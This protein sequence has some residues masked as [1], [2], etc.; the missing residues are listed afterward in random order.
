MILTKIHAGLGNQM[1]QYAFGRALALQRN[2]VL[3]FDI[4]SFDQQVAAEVSRRAY[5]LNVFNI[6]GEI[7]T[8][9]ELHAMRHTIFLTKVRQKLE[10]ELLHRIDLDSVARI[11]KTRGNIYLQGYW[12][13][14]EC[15]LGYDDVIRSE[16]TLRQP[17][18]SAAASAAKEI[19]SATT[20]IALH[21]RRGDNA[22]V[23]S[24]MNAFGTPAVAYYQNAPARII[25]EQ[26]ITN[27]HCFVFSDDVTWVQNNL[28][29]PWPTTYVSKPGIADYEEIILMSHCHHFAIANSTF[30]WWGAW[31]SS[32]PK[33]MV[34]TPEP[35]ALR[36]NHWFRSLY[37][38]T[39]VR[40]SRNG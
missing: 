11:R 30:S 18:S 3:K 15:F 35:Y 26:G 36:N 13:S 23:T 33:K 20:P 32:H 19:A 8:P 27:P 28:T 21:I 39:W 38:S 1:F 9:E 12:Q 5:T 25:E 7:A 4:R 14:P 40:M 6:V 16:F 34:I 10:I 31:L 29:L 2:D 24:S 17:L 22:T 37:P